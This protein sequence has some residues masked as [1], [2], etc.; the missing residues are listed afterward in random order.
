M[1]PV[2]ACQSDPKRSGEIENLTPSR[3]EVTMRLIFM[4]TSE[5]AVSSLRRL[6]TGGQDVAAVFT[7]PDKPAGRGNVLHPPPVK[8]FA[9]EHAIPVFQPAKIKTNEE[10]RAEFEQIAP[11][12]CIVAA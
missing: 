10:V 6:V 7:Q 2:T 12:A 1:T 5:F 3:Y 9:L 4:G 8:L 11:D